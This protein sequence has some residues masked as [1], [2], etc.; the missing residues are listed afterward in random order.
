MLTEVQKKQFDK[1]GFLVIP[2]AVT[3]AQLAAMRAVFDG[4]VAESY[5]YA[6]NRRLYNGSRQL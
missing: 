2:D 1:D 4:W 5:G 6:G 3:P